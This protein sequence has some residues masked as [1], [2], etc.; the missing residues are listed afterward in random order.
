MARK[1]P[2]EPGEYAVGRGRPPEH[3]RFKPGQSGNP[4]GRRKGSVNLKTL[5]QRVAETE[6]T[7]N[8]NGGERRVSLVEGVLLR[9]AQEA[10]RG[11]PR[12]AE[13]FLDMCHR[14]LPT[15]EADTAASLPD[16]DEDI[17]NRFITWTSKRDGADND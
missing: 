9:V 10:I 2:R 13:T 17:L 16:E 6:I 3:S 1:P 12:S 7:L 5:M 4:T 14:H 8:D 11:N 15:D